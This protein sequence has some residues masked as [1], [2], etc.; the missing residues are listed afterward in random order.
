MQKNQAIFI[1]GAPGSGKDVVI[2]D[3]TSNYNIIEFTATQID[4]MLSNDTAFKR[5]LPEKQESL[6]E[7]NSILITANSFNLNFALTKQVLESIGYSAHLILVETNLSVSIERLKTRNNLK[8]SLERITIGNANRKSIL[9]L[10]ESNIIVDNS[11]TLDLSEARIYILDILSELS[12]KSDLTLED[13]AK[14]RIKKKL[15][16]IVPGDVTDTR[17]MTPGSWSVYNG[18]AESYEV[19]SFDT[20]P[21]ATS[22]M[23]KLSSSTADM[24]SDDDKE[25]TRRVLG[26]IKKINFKKVVP[27]GIG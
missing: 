7:R 16:S 1:I 18:V 27:Y 3:I 20:S 4:E 15:K 25:R 12:F 8:E 14:P 17:G 24:R 26:K 22:P 21:I 19:F 11:E 10:F 5:A 2:R 6:L 23:Q 13:I 9:E